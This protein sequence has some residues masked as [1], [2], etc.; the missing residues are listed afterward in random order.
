[1]P[2]LPEV[3]T[4]RRSIAAAVGCRICDVV[5]PPSSLKSILIT[6]RLDYLRRRVVG[7][8]IASVSRL[9]KRIILELTD[10]QSVKKLSGGTRSS[11]L[12]NKFPAGDAIVI[13][14]RMSGL[15]LR[16][17]PPDRKHLRLVFQLE[18]GELGQILFWDQRGLGVVRLLAAEELAERLG[19]QRLGPDALNITVTELQK[20]LSSTRRAIKVALLDQRL[21]AGI[22]N[23]YA[24]EI[25]HFA[26]IH[27]AVPS[28]RLPTDAWPKL[29]Q[30][31]RSVL[32]RAIRHRG[33]TLSDGTYRVARRRKGNFQLHLRVYGRAGEQCRSCSQAQVLRI[34]QAQRSTYYCPVCQPMP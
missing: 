27:P 2:E 10:G 29:H 31:M 34:V 5:R 7:R 12:E 14:P 24:A 15:V 1:M 30:A 19:P 33:T 28:D 11:F 23:I 22:G 4:M 20:R 18:G 13:E 6:P 9:G 3:E 25:L 26:G 21:L 32:R 8:R 16:F 17:D